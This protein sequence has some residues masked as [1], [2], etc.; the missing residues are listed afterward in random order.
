MLAPKNHQIC[1]I[2]FYVFFSATGESREC[3]R[4]S[5]LKW[6]ELLMLCMLMADREGQLPPGSP[7]IAEAQ[8]QLASILQHQED[9]AQAEALLRSALAT[10]EKVLG[11]Q[12]PLTTA[13]LASMPLSN[14]WHHN[15]SWQ[16]SSEQCSS[17]AACS[18]LAIVPCNC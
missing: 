9:V 18:V 12:N 5:Q 4:F 16:I 8:V 10:R 6:C 17:I 11:L 13:T 2:I 14:K 1:G 7:Q 3:T 15:N